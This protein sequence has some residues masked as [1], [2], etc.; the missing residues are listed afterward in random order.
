M[1]LKEMKQIVKMMDFMIKTKD[2]N[3][4]QVRVKNAQ[5]IRIRQFKKYNDH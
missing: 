4:F 1:L 2:K 5:V 3:H